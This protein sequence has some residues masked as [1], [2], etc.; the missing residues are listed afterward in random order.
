EGALAPAGRRD[1]RLERALAAVGDRREAGLQAGQGEAQPGA[2][3][4]RRSGGRKRALEGGR[5]HQRDARC[6][7]A[8]HR[9][10]SLAGQ[11]TPG[12]PVATMPGSTIATRTPNGRHST[13]SASLIAA[14]ANLEA[15]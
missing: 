12:K 1:Q 13:A 3:R 10:G 6:A 8:A 9:T 14:S 4:P 11:S 15:W 7:R 2:D 5:R